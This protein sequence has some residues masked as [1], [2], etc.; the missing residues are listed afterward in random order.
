[1]DAD[2]IHREK[3]RELQ[4]NAMIYSEQI[5]EATSHKTAAVWSLTF[6]LKNYPSKINKT[7]WRIKEK[8]QVMFSYGPLRMEVPVLVNQ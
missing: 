7:C 1:M 3:S 4:R 5:L 6:P 8:L 2:K